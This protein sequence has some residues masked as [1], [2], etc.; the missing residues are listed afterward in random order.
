MWE[1]GYA[2]E[3][4]FRLFSRSI[5]VWYKDFLF[6]FLI[7]SGHQASA[8]EYGYQTFGEHFR[9]MLCFLRKVMG[10][11]SLPIFEKWEEWRLPNHQKVPAVRGEQLYV[12]THILVAQDKKV[13]W[14]VNFG[15]THAPS[16]G[17]QK[18][19]SLYCGPEIRG[20]SG[21]ELPR[22]FNTHWRWRVCL[23]HLF[24][25]LLEGFVERKW[26]KGSRIKSLKP[27]YP[28]SLEE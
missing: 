17:C 1:D 12:G 26:V 2:F 18:L 22:L 7:F 6:R 23:F 13:R 5:S 15:Q 4:I 8:D 9:V 20:W 16:E 27:G 21:F 19:L 14:N 28:R 24:V 3:E 10:S 25:V 11:H